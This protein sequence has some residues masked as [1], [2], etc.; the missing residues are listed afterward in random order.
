[1]CIRDRLDLMPT[2]PVN[3]L[4]SAAPLLPLS[5]SEV[6]V[7]DDQTNGD[8]R[9]LRL[10]VKSTYPAGYIMSPADSSTQVVAATISAASGSKRFVNDASRARDGIGWSL[11][12]Y[13]PPAEGLELILEVKP[14]SPLKLRTVD[15]VY[16]LPEIPGAPVKP[17]PAYILSLIHISEPT[18]LL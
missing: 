15:Q 9:T 1:M 6:K 10:S 7:L 18:R 16:G 2:A 12:F 13:A 4:K 11:N 3:Y 17:R 14:G 8:V 5:P